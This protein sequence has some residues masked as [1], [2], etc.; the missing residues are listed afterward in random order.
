MNDLTTLLPTGIQISYLVA[1]SLF[2]L[3]LKKLGSPA[4]ARNGN[5]FAASGMLLAVVATL[6]DQQILNYQWVLIGVAIGSAIGVIIAKTVAMTAM[7]QMVGFL[8]G[9]GGAASALVAMGE[10]WRLVHSEAP[11]PF[12]ATLTVILGIFIGGATLSGSLIAVGKLQ[13]VITGKPVTFPLQQL[14]NIA[15]AG[16]FVVSSGF[17]IANTGDQVAFFT[18]IG[19]ATVFG[20]LFVLPIGG[21]DMPVVISL[22]N[23]LSGLAASAAGFVV[24]NNMLIIA[25]ALV[26]ASGLILTEIMCKG[27]NRSLVSVLFGAFGGG[28]SGGVPGAEGSDL[29]DK[30]VRSIGSEEAAMML[31][32]ARSVVIVPGYGMAVAQAQQAIQELATLLE[33]SGVDVRYAIHP[34]AGRM[35]G[36][37]NVLLAEAN[38][39]YT[40]L[41]DM[42]DI[43]PQFEKTDVALI[44]GANDVV[45]PGAR[46]DAGSPIYGM[47]ILEVDKAK[48]TIVIKRSLGT[49]FSGIQNE[50]LFQDKTTMLFGSAKE[51]LGELVSE[52]KQL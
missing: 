5:V 43:N 38:V 29:A 20:V 52:V 6:L 50:L 40:Q 28:E 19:L 3:G 45:N 41:Y 15:I 21:G 39:P 46:H 37:M 16:A 18:M 25:G 34:V 1:A 24:M 2:I 12:N 22:L 14:I 42:D 13:G 4:T 17:L 30:V 51:M 23:S 8:N 44:V 9:L 27:M 47:P 26:G 35:P 36:H 48:Q 33:Q 31:R 49:G 7:P 10:F 11:V 32:Y